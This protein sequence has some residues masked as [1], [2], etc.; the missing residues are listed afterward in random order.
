MAGGAHRPVV[1]HGGRHLALQ[2]VP[3]RLC[4]AHAPRPR[5]VPPHDPEPA[6]VQH[7]GAAGRE[8]RDA[9]RE[10][11]RRPGPA[12]CR[13]QCTGRRRPADGRI[14]GGPG[15][16]LAGGRALA[17]LHPGQPGDRVL[18]RADDRARPAPDRRPVRARPHDHALRRGRR[19]HRPAPEPLALRDLLAFPAAGL[20]RRVR[21]AAV[22]VRGSSTDGP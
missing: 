5:L 22:P 16:G 12:R 3:V 4:D 10:Q 17:L 21:R 2:P 15:A 9:A 13:A 7:A 6:L 8:R 19:D 14:P 1:L 18:L 20:A 11:P